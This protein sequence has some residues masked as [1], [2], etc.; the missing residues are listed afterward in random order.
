MCDSFHPIQIILPRAFHTRSLVRAHC[1]VIPIPHMTCDSNLRTVHRKR[2]L[3]VYLASFKIS[4]AVHC[5]LLREG[6]EAYVYSC[7]FFVNVTAH[8][9]L[10]YATYRICPMITETAA[11]HV[12]SFGSYF[13]R[14]THAPQLMGLNA[15]G[16]RRTHC[17][18]ASNLD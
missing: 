16:K 1:T 11:V 9:R 8:C 10:R 5:S 3:A 18:L 12:V 15:Q 13:L 17:N 2:L 6:N 14:R 7:T 4:S